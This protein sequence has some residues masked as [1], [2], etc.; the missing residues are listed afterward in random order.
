MNEKPSIDRFR[1]KCRV[2]GVH[3]HSSL[4]PTSGKEAEIESMTVTLQ[5]VFGGENDAANKDWSKW[6][7]SGQL[8]LQISNPNV[9]PLLKNG[10]CFFV[11]FVPAPES[12]A[13]LGLPVE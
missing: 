11:D 8:Q 1:A 3:N 10:A 13:Q 4:H 2:I 12:R 5:P 6:T 7:P 9:F